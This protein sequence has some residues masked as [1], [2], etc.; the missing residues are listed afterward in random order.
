MIRRTGAT[1]RKAKT[2]NGL[3]WWIT[4]PIHVV[5]RLILWLLKELVA[6]LWL[7]L[8]QGFRIGYYE[9]R[10]ERTIKRCKA[11]GIEIYDLEIWGLLRSITFDRQRNRKGEVVCKGCKQPTT[12]PHCHHIKHVARHPRLAFTPSN[13]VGLCGPCHQDEHPGVPLSNVAPRPSPL[14]FRR[15]RKGRRLRGVR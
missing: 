8:I 7:G 4:W 12:S 9:A 5:P 13:L 15:G 11:A 14:P 2:M 10:A 6:G 3:L 1:S